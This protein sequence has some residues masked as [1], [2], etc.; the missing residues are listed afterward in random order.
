MNS[1]NKSNTDLKT[2]TPQN[3]FEIYYPNMLLKIVKEKKTELKQ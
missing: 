2:K 1:Y 3:M